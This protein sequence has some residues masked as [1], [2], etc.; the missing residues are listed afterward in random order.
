MTQNVRHSFWFALAMMT[1]IVMADLSQAKQLPRIGLLGWM[2]C[3]QSMPNS[4]TGEW[5]FFLQGLEEYGYVVG[6]NV[7]IDC[8][9]ANKRADAFRA[10]ATELVRLPVDVIVTRSD[11]AAVAAG[12]ATLSIP[13]VTLSSSIVSLANQGSHTTGIADYSFGLTDKRLEL[14]KKAMPAIQTVGVLS[15]PVG[16]YKGYEGRARRAA[17]DLNLQ[18]TFFRC[19]DPSELQSTFA[20]MTS[21]RIDAVLIS[22]DIMF[23]SYASQ[24][25]D[26]AI[27][28]RLPTVAWDNR[29]IQVGFLLS[30]SIDGAAMERRLAYYVDRILNG[31][32]PADIPIEQPATFV[33][34]INLHTAHALGIILPQSLLMMAD[35]VVE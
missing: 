5:T 34:S 2:P 8:R 24:I 33:I 1:F 25:A 16:F 17:Q 7:I 21:Q 13:I 15:D 31:V 3:D 19:K 23:A 10:A 26:L 4:K 9:S 12:S 20:A 32:S 30:Y 14:L 28:N 27:K 29:L 6:K 35:E 11:T 22:P 18:L